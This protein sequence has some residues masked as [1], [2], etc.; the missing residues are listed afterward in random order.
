MFRLLALLPNACSGFLNWSGCSSCW[1]RWL[2][3]RYPNLLEQLQHRSGTIYRVRE[4]FRFGS[5]WGGDTGHG[6]DW[7]FQMIFRQWP[8]DWFKA[9]PNI[10]SQTHD[11]WFWDLLTNWARKGKGEKWWGF[12]GFW[13]FLID[14]EKKGFFIFSR[15]GTSSC[16]KGQLQGLPWPCWMWEETRFTSWRTHCDW[17][18]TQQNQ[19]ASFFL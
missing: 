7:I 18:E 8:E 12:W 2:S 13:S 5:K 4:G 3:S 10:F 17:F 14:Q 15:H 16:P 9:A 11:W 19:V 1:S 6:V